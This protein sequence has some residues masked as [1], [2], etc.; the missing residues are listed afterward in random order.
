MVEL[1]YTLLPLHQDFFVWL[2]SEKESGRHIV[3]LITS[4]SGWLGRR[5]TRVIAQQV[6]ILETPLQQLLKRLCAGLGSLSAD[7]R[8]RHP[9]QSLLWGC[10]AKRNALKGE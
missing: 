10:S 6:D 5:L 3:P 8:L 7:I 4:A 2:R 1:D 9:T